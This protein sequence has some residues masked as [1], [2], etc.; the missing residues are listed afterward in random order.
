MQRTE[1]GSHMQKW[2]VGACVHTHSR[3]FMSMFENFCF[4]LIVHSMCIN[5]GQR[6]QQTCSLMHSHSGPD[7]EQKC[8]LQN[9]DTRVFPERHGKWRS[10]A[11]PVGAGEATIILSL[12]NCHNFWLSFPFYSHLTPLWDLDT[13]GPGRTG[14]MKP[15]EHEAKM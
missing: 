11:Q 13:K 12:E 4:G 1:T 15:V 7:L 2:C 6:S 5:V 3:T 8:S 10:I 9:S 14:L